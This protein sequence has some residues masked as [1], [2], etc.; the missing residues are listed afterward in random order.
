MGMLAHYLLHNYCSLLISCFDIIV[1]MHIYYC[2]LEVWWNRMMEYATCPM[3]STLGVEDRYLAI[4]AI[5][6]DFVS[7]L[8]MS[9]S[10]VFVFSIVSHTNHT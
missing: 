4:T 2:S 5:L 3:M 7:L 1:S 6:V 10:I 9:R 8:V